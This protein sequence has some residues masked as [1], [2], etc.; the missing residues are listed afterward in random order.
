MP[1]DKIRFEEQAASVCIRSPDRAKVQG[2]ECGGIDGLVV[3]TKKTLK[4]A[5]CNH[6]P[7][8]F[9]LR[10][11][12]RSAYDAGVPHECSF[13]KATDEQLNV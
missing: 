13:R 9:H 6:G 10:D 2:L 11:L 8:R 12:S 4:M 3:Q 7:R 5:P 1:V